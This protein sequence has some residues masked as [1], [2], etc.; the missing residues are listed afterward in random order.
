MTMKPP[1]CK[2]IAIVLI[3]VCAHNTTAR[4][5][6][7]AQKGP[8]LTCRSVQD[9]KAPQLYGMWQVSFTNPPAGLPGAAPVLLEKHEEFSDSVQGVVTRKLA[10]PQ[11]AKDG[12][13]PQIG[14]AHV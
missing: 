1:A 4:A 6:N 7:D 3:A 13:A 2:L 12:H 8:N 11:N 10:G 5:Q 14:R 9:I